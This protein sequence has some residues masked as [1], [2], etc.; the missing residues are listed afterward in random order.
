MA[1]KT[2]TV[3]LSQLRDF[4]DQRIEFIQANPWLIP[5]GLAIEM[6]PLALLIHGHAKASIYKKKNSKSNV[7]KN[8]AIN[9]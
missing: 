7:K 4:A 3:D 8:K 1:K 5:A 2:A 9:N 6:I